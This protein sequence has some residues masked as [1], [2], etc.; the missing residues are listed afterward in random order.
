MWANPFFGVRDSETNARR[1]SVGKLS[2]IAPQ[3]IKH[4]DMISNYKINQNWVNYIY[5]HASNC[6]TTTNKY[7]SVC[8]YYHSTSILED[9]S[10]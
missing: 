4:Q 8:D 3:R 6:P 2:L 10:S 7:N 9:V 1:S 5:Q